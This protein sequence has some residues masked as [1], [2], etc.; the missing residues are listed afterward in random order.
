MAE[1]RYKEVPATTDDDAI[2]E[3]LLVDLFESHAG[4]AVAICEELELPDNTLG[5]MLK[6]PPS[7]YDE[8]RGGS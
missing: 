1:R 6:S 2:L 4:D 3:A 7:R 8:G 5:L